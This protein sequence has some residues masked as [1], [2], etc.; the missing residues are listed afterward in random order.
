M[1]R[2]SIVFLSII[3]L[4][5]TDSAFPA[6]LLPASNDFRSI[7]FVNSGSLGS[8]MK[9]SYAKPVPGPD[10]S[11]F[12]VLI[13]M[14][15]KGFNRRIPQASISFGGQLNFLQGISKSVLNDVG[16]DQIIFRFKT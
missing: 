13:G 12:G 6:A 10:T 1:R 7:R 11:V 9:V 8:E 16:L 3:V 14:L 4:R 15:P 5:I 2:E